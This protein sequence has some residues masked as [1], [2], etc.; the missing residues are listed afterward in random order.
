MIESSTDHSDLRA[1]AVQRVRDHVEKHKSRERAFFSID[2]LRAV[3]DELD[4]KTVALKIAAHQLQKVHDDAFRQCAG[5]GLV[6]SD[7]RDFSCYE[8]NV[9]SEAARAARKVFKGEAP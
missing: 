9:C 4:R 7:G 8:I 6:T 2:G 3:L 1:A 5:Y